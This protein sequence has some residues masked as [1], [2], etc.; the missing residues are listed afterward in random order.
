MY[1]SKTKFEAHMETEHGM[2]DIIPN[3]W[4]PAIDQDNEDLV[5]IPSKAEFNFNTFR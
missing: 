3:A 2:N 5:A 4:L 1:V